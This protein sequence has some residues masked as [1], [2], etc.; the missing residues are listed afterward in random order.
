MTAKQTL[1]F[2]TMITTEN[3]LPVLLPNPPPQEP[4]LVTDDKGIKGLTTN[5]LFSLLKDFLV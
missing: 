1:L 4:L 5:P 3:L 2:F